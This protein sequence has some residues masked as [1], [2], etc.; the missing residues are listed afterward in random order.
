MMGKFPLSKG[1]FA[2]QARDQ[3]LIQT[4]PNLSQQHNILGR[5]RRC[6]WFLGSDLIDDLNHLEDHKGQQNEVD[7]DGNE[8]AIS[9]DG[10]TSLFEGIKGYGSIIWKAA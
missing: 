6:F 3:L 10:D 9:E 7:G 1:F 8:V 4:I 5:W 2:T